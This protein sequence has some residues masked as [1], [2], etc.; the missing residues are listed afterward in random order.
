MG[1]P[2]AVAKQASGGVPFWDEKGLSKGGEKGFPPSSLDSTWLARP[3]TLYHNKPRANKSQPKEMH[4]VCVTSLLRSHGK[5]ST[6]CGPMRWYGLESSKLLRGGDCGSSTF[7]EARTTAY[8]PIM[9]AL[10]VPPR[11]SA[12][13]STSRGSRCSRAPGTCIS[14]TDW[15]VRKNAHSPWM[16]CTLSS[17]SRRGRDLLG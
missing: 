1:Y 17:S 9:D 11:G 7:E 10:P 4:H 5:A 14:M 3:S 13:T 2:G 15:P 12:S 16:W 8:R 6:A